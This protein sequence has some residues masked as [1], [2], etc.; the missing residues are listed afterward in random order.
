MVILAFTDPVF[1]PAMRIISGITNANPALVTTTFDHDYITGE[2]LRLNIPAGYGM[3]QANQLYAPI[4]VTS[5]TTFTIA[6]DT[7][8]FD[9]FIIPST[10][11]DDRQYAQV[12]PIGEINELLAA[13]TT[14]VL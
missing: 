3:E 13:A 1:Q 7:I 10:F 12:T 14:N 6:I 8:L 4:I 11:P 9:T 2:I 5:P